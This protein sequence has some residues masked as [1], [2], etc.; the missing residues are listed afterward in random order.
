MLRR[1]GLFT[2]PGDPDDTVT[3]MVRVFADQLARDVPLKP[4]RQAR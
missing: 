3:H 4:R 1:D 2:R